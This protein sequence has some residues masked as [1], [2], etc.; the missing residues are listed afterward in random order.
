MYYFKKNDENCYT[1]EYHLDFMRDNGLRKMEVF[2]AKAETGTGY[3]F[4]KE[5]QETGESYQETCGKICGKY[6]PRNGK[7][8]RCRHSGFVYE[9]TDKSIIL[10]V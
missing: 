4:C 2:E 3:F 1:K 7:N 10:K 8:G 6:S 9:K 5:F